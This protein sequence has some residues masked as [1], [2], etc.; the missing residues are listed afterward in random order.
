MEFYERQMRLTDSYNLKATLVPTGI[1]T[2]DKLIEHIDTSVAFIVY[3][4]HGDDKSNLVVL[5]GWWYRW[6]TAP[7]II[8]KDNA[9]EEDWHN[10]YL[11]DLSHQSQK[12]VHVPIES[13][14]ETFP[15]NPSVVRRFYTEQSVKQI[16]DGLR[17]AGWGEYFAKN[18]EWPRSFIPIAELSAHIQ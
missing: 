12:I 9:R 15:F 14:P 5:H 7:V 13:V 3:R 11:L 2:L 17:Q 16:L 8:D 4:W 6:I 10:A 1:N 18:M